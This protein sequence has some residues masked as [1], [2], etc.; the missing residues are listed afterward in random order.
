MSIDF[1]T[2]TRKNM[3]S[4]QALDREG[5]KRIL[6][7]LSLFATVVLVC[8]LVT[9]TSALAQQGSVTVNPPHQFLGPAPG[10]NA[11][12]QYGCDQPLATPSGGCSPSSGPPNEYL[13]PVSPSPGSTT[14]GSQN[15]TPPANTNGPAPIS[16][17]VSP[18]GSGT[19]S[20]SSA[21]EPTGSPSSAM[22]AGSSASASVG[23]SSENTS[24]AGASQSAAVAPV[25]VLPDT[26]GASISVLGAGILL[27]GGGLVARRLIS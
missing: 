27:V 5:G 15:P 23:A 12:D 16:G 9:A 3:S 19:V 11:G 25:S 20:A 2:W 24:G 1:S 17:G 18:S 8:T 10:G 21:S 4:Q 14:T 22:S 6:K 7:R 26:G 13:G